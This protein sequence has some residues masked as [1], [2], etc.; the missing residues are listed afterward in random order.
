MIYGI[1]VILDNL[2]NKKKTHETWSEK[3]ALLT[4]D[5]KGIIERVSGS[6]VIPNAY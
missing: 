6:D 4:F 5:K 3:T 1:A 2:K